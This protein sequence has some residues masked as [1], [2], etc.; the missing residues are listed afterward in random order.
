MAPVDNM[1]PVPW[2]T[3]MRASGHLGGAAFAA[4][5]AHRLDDEEH[6]PHPGVT[7]REA[8]AVGVG[9]EPAADLEAT[10]LDEG[11]ALTLG[12]EPEVLDGQH[13]P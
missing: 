7:R 1:P 12:A 3:A 5:L 10:V 8:A 9:R 4:Q 6:A 13:A 11:T 2:A